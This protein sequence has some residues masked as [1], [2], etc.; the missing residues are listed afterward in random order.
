MKLHI[1]NRLL[2][3]RQE[4][5]N[6]LAYFKNANKPQ[7]DFKFWNR[8]V[9]NAGNGQWSKSRKKDKEQNEVSLKF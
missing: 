1:N 2:A 5:A 8:K 9:F 4:F 3:P 7:K 6:A